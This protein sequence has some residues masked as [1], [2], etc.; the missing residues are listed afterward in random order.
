[1][2][3]RLGSLRLVEQSLLYYSFQSKIIGTQVRTPR[4]LRSDYAR[5]CTYRM[6]SVQNDGEGVLYV[7]YRICFLELE[8]NGGLIMSVSVTV[9][10]P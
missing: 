5:Q 4:Q 1:V 10:A 6:C 7:L 3:E 2:K 9:H 8:G